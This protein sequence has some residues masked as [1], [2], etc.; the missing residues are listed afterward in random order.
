MYLMIEG[1]WD[2][3]IESSCTPSPTPRHSPRGRGTAPKGGEKSSAWES[4]RG[5]VDGI[6]EQVLTCTP[7]FCLF[8]FTFLKVI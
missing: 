3:R 8:V 4:E 5:M 1:T 2:H 6:L 7:A